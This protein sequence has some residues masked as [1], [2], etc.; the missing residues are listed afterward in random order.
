MNGFS[1]ACDGGIAKAV[2]Q[3]PDLHTSY[4]SAP[5]G[6]EVTVSYAIS[7]WTSHGCAAE[8]AKE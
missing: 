8:L 5:H 6:Q 3:E 1:R 7:F 2:L 4:E